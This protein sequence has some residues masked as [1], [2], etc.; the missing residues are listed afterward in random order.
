MSEDANHADRGGTPVG[1]DA[2]AL[3]I[4]SKRVL[5]LSGS[6]HYPRSTPAMWPELMRRTKEAG[7]NAIDTYVFWNLH[8]SR[9]GIYD[10]AG[11][12]DLMRFCEL[13][14]EQGLWVILRIGPYIC[15]ETSYGGFPAWLRD[16][17]GMRMRTDNE[18]FKREMERWVRMLCHHL[19][20]MFAPNGG[21]IIAAQIENEYAL[22]AR[23]YGESGKRY[24]QWAAE[25]GRSLEL[26]VPLIMCEG[27]AGG[28][29]ET[30]NGFFA[31][32]RIEKH[33]AA[34]PDQPALW[35]EHWPGW[36]DT[37]G[38]P[39]HDRPPQTVAYG[40]ARFFAAG[41]T[42]VNYYMW[43]G[44]TNF[45]RQGMFLQATEYFGSAP[46]DE[47]GFETTRSNHLAQL[48][49]ILREYAELLLSDGPP[50]IKMLGEKQPR[51]AWG[52]AGGATLSFYCND[53]VDEDATVEAEGGIYHLPSR[54]VTLVSG[55]RV[56]MNTAQI[57]SSNVI[58]RSMRTVDK[59][60]SKFLTWPEPL[61]PDWP[62]SAAHGGV[63]SDGPIEQLLITRDSTDYC[64]Y[65]STCS[66]VEY[67]Q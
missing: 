49:G 65:S 30:I 8:E 57:E 18:P 22:V 46:L 17:P 42:G 64:W 16:V 12:L 27:A 7:L 50:Q 19:R 32:E 62:E 51:Y 4:N 15:A 63:E 45:G 52:T 47:F 5:L 6:I 54:S 9:R 58:Q 48:H 28:A 24:L 55:D 44:G 3:T 41:G 39:A 25:L 53:S 21:P 33:Q 37:W 40:V 13:A 38:V 36:Y 14:G 1:Y 23:Q 61:P 35:T 56:L 59:A 11:P 43:H 20:P 34:H 29:I 60:F 31:H 66:V 26:G 10:F 2:R 67:Q